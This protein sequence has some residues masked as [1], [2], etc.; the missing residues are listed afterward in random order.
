[1]DALQKKVALVPNDLA[2]GIRCRELCK[3]L[4]DMIDAIEQWAERYI[5]I[6]QAGGG[7]E[8][9]EISLRRSLCGGDLAATDQGSQEG[10]AP[11]GQ[12]SE[13]GRDLW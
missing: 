11:I 5:E 1:M 2:S 3:D 7:I 4:V 12:M 13:D 9:L 6:D 10:L 8:V